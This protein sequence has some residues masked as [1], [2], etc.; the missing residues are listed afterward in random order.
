MSG[1]G[2][3]PQNHDDDRQV[4]IFTFSGPLKPDDVKAWNAAIGPLL[5]QFGT[6]LSGVTMEGVKNKPKPGSGRPK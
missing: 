5:Y 1:G 6:S 4:V 2:I 3:G